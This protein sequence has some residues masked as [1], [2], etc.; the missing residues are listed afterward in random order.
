MHMAHDHAEIVVPV[1]PWMAKRGTFE[2]GEPG[3]AGQLVGLGIERMVPS[4]MCTW[5]FGVDLNL[6]LGL[7]VGMAWSHC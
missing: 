5:A 4:P 1:V 3:Y 7:S 2:L 6:P